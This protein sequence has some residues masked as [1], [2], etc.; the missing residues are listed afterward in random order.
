MKTVQKTFPVNLLLGGRKC[1]VVGAGKVATRKIGHLLRV[2]AD[3]TVIAP[4]ISSKVNDVAEN[5]KIRLVKREYHEHDIE[6]FFLIFA[7][8]DDKKLNAR[9]IKDC[10]QRGILCSA[11]DENW[12]NGV[13]ITPASVEKNGVTISV[14]TDGAACRRTRMI[15]DHLSR[16]LE[17]TERTEMV[18]I[19]TD[20]NYL[21]LKDR[22]SLHLVGDCFDNAGEMLTNLTGVH[23][24]ILV[25]TCNRIEFA[26]FMSPSESLEKLLVKIL[27]FENIGEDSYYIK[28]GF[29]AFTHFAFVCSGL[30]SQTPGEKHVTA[31][32]KSSIEYCRNKGWS[33]SMM[34]DWFDNTLHLS[35]HIR[36]VVEPLLTAVEIEDLALR[37]VKDKFSD[38]K[39]KNIMLVGTGIIGQAIAA[40]ITELGCNL[41]WCY[42][43]NPPSLES[44]HKKKTKICTLDEMKDHLGK[45]DVII[46]VVSTPAHI[47]HDEHVPFMEQT[48]KIIVI[49]LGIPRNVSPEFGKL[50]P[51]LTVVDLDDLKHWHKREA[52]D[53]S[54]LFELSMRIVSEHK[55]IYEKII[56]GAHNIKINE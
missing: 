15:K 39:K 25:N 13:F 41:V 22:E 54:H 29:D 21:S 23:E 52:I 38:L 31:Q 7:A 45:A 17:F 4:K 1:L 8:T 33:G 53:M 18:I 40:K 47:I 32:L 12:K 56:S 14:S 3:I 24:F 20:Q 11:I 27:G 35:K 51:S 19:G 44:M 42:H 55:D 43:M 2:H 5:G 16:H 46:T 37:Y 28:K 9:I 36:Q 26:A 34:Q 6:G 30:M 10:N 49:D 50:L 48:K